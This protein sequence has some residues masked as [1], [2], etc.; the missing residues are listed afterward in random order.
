MC[1]WNFWPIPPYYGYNPTVTWLNVNYNTSMIQ[2]DSHLNP[3]A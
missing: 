3:F 1:E 2:L